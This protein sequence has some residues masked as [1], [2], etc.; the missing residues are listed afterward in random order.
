MKIGIY[1]GCFNPP[2]K[3]HKKIA[4]LLIKEG[5]IDKVIYVPTADTYD[6]KDLAPFVKRVKMLNLMVDN[7]DM[8]VSDICKAGEYSYT[9]QVL[10][11]YKEK[12]KDATLYFICGTDNLNYLYKWKEYKY[13]LENYKILVVIRN[14]DD[15]EKILDKYVDFKN[16]IKLANIEPS[17]VSST[18]IRKHIKDN[19]YEKLNGLID[20]K[21]VEYI[22]KSGLYKV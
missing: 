14:N 4:Q 6:K 22:K 10:D 17:N 3:M 1:G 16:N 20:E 2:H 8:L 9:Y 11:Y 21:I 5:Y 13:I 12:Y 7:V 18:I 19:E 15:I